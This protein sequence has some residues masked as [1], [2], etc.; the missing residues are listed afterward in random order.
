MDPY[1]EAPWIWPD[2]HHGLISNIQGAL[3]PLLKPAYVARLEAR[4]YI[5]NDEDPGRKVMVPDVRIDETS[6][7]RRHK[8]GSGGLAIA[9]PMVV[10]QLID[11]EIEEAYIT[12]QEPRSR[13]L[14]TVIELL[15]PTN[16]IGGAEGRKSF[17]KKKRE[18][19]A[20][21]VNRVEID[22]LRSG[23]SSVTHPPLPV[24]DYRVLTSRGVSHHKARCWPVGVR[25]KLPVIGIPLKEKED[26]V[27][28]DL[29]AVL[30]AA[31]ENGAY[32]V[33]VDY[34][35]PPDPPLNPDDARWANKLL[36]TK[37]LR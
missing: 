29:N 27:P 16:K 18:I 22:L 14:I 3:N 17:M 25:Q 36:K 31:Y 21:E 26:D 2:V 7:V 9:E 8:R 11:E 30:V 15:S 5:S 20:S 13:R 28:L 33:S 10:T 12:I 37:G 24:S 34:T 19:L 35:R 32:G 6:D 1:L 4:I 23:L